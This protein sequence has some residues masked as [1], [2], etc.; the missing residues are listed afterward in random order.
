MFK[1][2]E[3]DEVKVANPFKDYSRKFLQSSKENTVR[4][5]STIG[6]RSSNTLRSVATSR[7]K[8]KTTKVS[9]KEFSGDTLGQSE[10]GSVRR[11]ESAS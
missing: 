1:F 3:V 4:S 8:L 11:S 6:G 5:F 2:E 7:S 10:S 9:K